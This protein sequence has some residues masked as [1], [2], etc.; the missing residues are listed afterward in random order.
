MSRIR[1]NSL[2]ILLTA[3]GSA[4]SWWPVLVQPSLDLPFWVS[5]VCV[6]LCTSLAMTLA[7]LSW[8]LLLLA[9]G[10]GTFGGICLSLFI[11]WPSD[12]LAAAYIPVYLVAMTL[13]AMFIALF[14]GLIIRRRSISNEAS[15]R[16]V[17][18][19]I[20]ACVAFGPVTLAL[21]PAIV[22]HRIARND[23]IAAERFASLKNAVESTAKADGLS[24]ICDGIALQRRYVGPPFSDTDWERITG[25]FV[26]QD[27]YNFMIY[28]REKGGYTISAA[29]HRERVDGT[30]RFCTDESGRVGCGMERDASRYKC[31]PCPK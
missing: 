26:R 23:R 14:A 13:V 30:R 12:P 8:P 16:A 17:W 5:L 6:A 10:L 7:P 27:G 15:R 28:C 21:A 1:R 19:A 29:P 31:L 3:L 20:V 22:R 2:L 4:V 9:S 24:Q 18:A 11:W 25:N